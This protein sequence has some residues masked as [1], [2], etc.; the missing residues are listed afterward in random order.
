MM[1][2]MIQD[3][4]IIAFE[5]LDSDDKVIIACENGLIQVVQPTAR[6]FATIIVDGESRIEVEDPNGRSF[7]IYLDEQDGQYE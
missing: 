7:M 3:G 2:A 4:S 6:P 5:D 1:H